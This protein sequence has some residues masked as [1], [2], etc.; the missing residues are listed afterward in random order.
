MSVY[1]TTPTFATTNLTPGVFGSYFSAFTLGAAGPTGPIGPQG[2]AGPIGAGGAVSHFG[3][4]SDS[5]TQTIASATTAYA[6]TFN[7]T[8]AAF[9]VS[10]GTPASRIVVSQVG[11]YDVQFSVQLENSSSSDGD[12]TL[13][14]RK[15]GVDLSGTSGLVNVPGRQGS[16]NG[17]TIAGW[18]YVLP[19]AANDYVELVWSASATSIT[20]PHYAA[21]TSPTRPATA[22][23]ILTVVQST[24]TQ[25]GPTGAT[26]PVGPAGETG[27][28]GP[29][30]SAATV[31]VGATTT[32][33]AGTSA[34]ATN[35]GTSSAAVIN[36]VIPRGDTGAAGATGP[37]GATGATGPAGPAPSGTGL[38]SVT[39]GVLDTP[40]TLSA[41]VAADAPNLRTQL[42]L[43]TLATQSSV[44][45]NSL[46]GTPTFPLGTVTA[47][48]PLSISQTWNSAGT[49]F[50]GLLLNV[51]DT[52][53]AAGSTLLDLQVGGTSI[54]SVRKDYAI[55]LRGVAVI[56]S[57]AANQLRFGATGSYCLGISSSNLVEIS[58]SIGFTG[59]SVGGGAAD[60]LISRDGGNALAMRNG[61]SPQ[62]WR[63]YNVQNSGTSYERAFLSWSSNELLIGTEKGSSGGSAR[64]LKL[65]TDGTTR[66][67][68]TTTG[69][70]YVG[71]GAAALATTATDGFFYIP[72][73]AGTP[74][75]TPTAITGC[76]PLVAD[77]TNNRVYC[78]LGG[79]WVALN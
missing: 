72:T 21:G 55:M 30:G 67:G 10:I 66:A 4:F 43:G 70:V 13:W 37:A 5:T 18:N 1:A 36:F 79:A 71:S 2:P 20:M 34:S 27:P 15:N 35:V 22:S 52:A 38:V 33:A 14:L 39:A 61:G 57:N 29:S 17:H 24:Y 56:Q 44:P 73:C 75:G 53:S 74:T 50:N 78:Y 8:D 42:G 68:I 47:S 3:S 64:P 62:S 76:A 60:A 9:G 65:Q 51:T 54:C 6:V 46:T 19:L 41:R 77:S 49:T 26:G 45:Y 59:G 69:N 11:N 7:A 28:A 40:T 31:A 32:G 12:A 23:A 25:L 58:T 63:V 16:T 48:T